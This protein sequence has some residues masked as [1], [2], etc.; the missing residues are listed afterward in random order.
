MRPADL[1]HRK[2]FW[3]IMALFGLALL[4]LALRHD[5]QTALGLPTDVF[6]SVLVSIVL[7]AFIG[8]SVIAFVRDRPFAAFSAI[9]FWMA[10]SAVIGLGYTYR[11]ELRAAGDRLMAQLIPGRP[12]TSG[13]V[14]EL[15]RG[16]AGEFQVTTQ[17][18]GAKIPTVL[19]T[20]ATAVVL[21]HDA[22][23]AAGLPVDMLPYTVSVD[24]ANGRTRAAS[25]TLDKIG[26][27]G[28]IERSVPALIAQP[29]QLRVSLLGMTFL[30]R[31]ESWEVRGD[32]LVLRGYP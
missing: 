11:F 23:K 7:I 16:R 26:V 31:L 8:G 13:R 12:V 1:L 18:N 3:A 28:L 4:V 22:A 6:G 19:D 24:T 17:I 25:V 5:A 30:D 32:R 14:V 10:A 21:T 29:G 20:G 15:A 2:L 27:G 9:L